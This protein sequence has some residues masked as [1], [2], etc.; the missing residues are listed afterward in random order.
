MAHYQVAEEMSLKVDLR[1]PGIPQDAE[2]E[3]Q[4]RM[5]KIQEVVD[6]V[7]SEYQ[8]ESVVADLSKKGKFKKSSEE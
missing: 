2:L 3:D 1:I 4:E 8:T 5:T 7:R 6:K